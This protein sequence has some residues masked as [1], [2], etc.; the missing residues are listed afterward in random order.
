METNILKCANSIGVISGFYI[1]IEIQR[2]TE[3]LNPCYHEQAISYLDSN[4]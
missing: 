1:N 2:G 4:L 3:V